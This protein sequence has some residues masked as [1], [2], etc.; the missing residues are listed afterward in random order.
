MTASRRGAIGRDQKLL[1]ICENTPVTSVPMVAIA[2]KAAIE[3]K[4]ATIAY[5][6]AVAPFGSSF[7]LPSRERI[8]GYL[9]TSKRQ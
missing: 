4:K 9:V 7:I 5:S 2:E 8:T 6:I 3:M 1:A